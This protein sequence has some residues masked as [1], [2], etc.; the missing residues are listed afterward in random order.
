MNKQLHVDFKAVVISA[1]LMK[2]G[3]SVEHITADLTGSGVIFLFHDPRNKWV[4]QSYCTSKR[5][6]TGTESSYLDISWFLDQTLEYALY[7]GQQP[8][9]HSSQRENQ[10]EFE[11]TNIPQNFKK[12]TK[13]K[14]CWYWVNRTIPASESWWRILDFYKPGQVKTLNTPR[15]E[16][17]I[18]NIAKLWSE[19]KFAKFFYLTII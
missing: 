1:D 2:S 13:H 12:Y 19:K 7:W 8:C 3:V 18:L 15:L 6:R 10:L 4:A 17:I 16:V 11:W 9:F 5:G 14:Y